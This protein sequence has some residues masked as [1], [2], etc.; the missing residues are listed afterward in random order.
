MF[1]LQEIIYNERVKVP[2]GPVLTSQF[3]SLGVYSLTFH[4]HLEQMCSTHCFHYIF[5]EDEFKNIFEV[6]FLLQNMYKMW[7]SSQDSQCSI[8]LT[9]KKTKKSF[10]EM[11]SGFAQ[12][13]RF[14]NILI[15]T[16]WIKKWLQFGHLVLVNVFQQ[17]VLNRYVQSKLLSTVFNVT[18]TG[19]QNAASDLT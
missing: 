18:A 12:E 1:H 7:I 13:K 5:W 6:G 16:F 15:R 3:S 2:M 19:T 9:K 4:C 10:W 14:L 11:N 17:N 8:L